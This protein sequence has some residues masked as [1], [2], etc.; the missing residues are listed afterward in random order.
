MTL[1]PTESRVL[2]KLDISGLLDFISDLV[3]IPSVGG[4]ET[5]AQEWVAEWME[6]AGFEVDKWALD[7]PALRTHPAYS[8][9]INREEGLGVVGT[10]GQ[11]VGGRT[12]ILNGHVDVVPTGDPSSWTTPPW[13]GRVDGGRVYGRGALDMKGGLA[14]ALFAAKAIRDAGVKLTGQLQLHSV[15]GEEDG[16]VGTLAAILRGYRGDGAVIMEPTGLA[17]CP[18][19]A[20]A[21]N[22]RVTIRGRAA[23]GCVREEGVSALEKYHLVHQELLALEKRRNHN[24][25]DPLFRDYRIPF[26]V[27]VGKI[28]GGDWAS[29]VPDRVQVEGRYG[30]SPDEGM[31]E[32]QVAFQEALDR[33]GRI[34]PW[35]RDHPP[36]LVWWGGRFE[37]ARIPVDDPIIAEIQGALKSIGTGEACLR[38]VTFGSDMRLLVQEASIPTVLF[39]PGDIRMAHAADESVPVDDLE[40]TAKTLALT[41]LRFCGYQE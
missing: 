18:A 38:G 16:G 40:K 29:S 21:L 37:P 33:I 28:E 4:N 13:E 8:A 19:Q 30:L 34:D 9:E 2:S 14:S 22:F 23:H 11:A 17:I 12:L 1:S 15:I 5:A 35:L 3:R 36:E 20:G 31:N 27:S 39:G 41:A 32:A 6:G 7:L 26:P 24:C 25:R 10:I